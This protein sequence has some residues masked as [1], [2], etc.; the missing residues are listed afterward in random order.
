MHARNTQGRAEFCAITSKALVNRTRMKVV[1]I[2]LTKFFRRLSPS[3]PGLTRQSIRF[4]RLFAK[5]D[6]YAGLRLAEG[7]SAPQAG[8]A[9]VWRGVWCA[10]AQR[11]ILYACPVA[12]LP[13]AAC[14]AARRAIGT[15]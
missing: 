3:L 15:R 11:R 14:A 9:R 12:V 4:E 2:A 7:A 8:Q 6:G 10:R 5:R 13:S 1:N